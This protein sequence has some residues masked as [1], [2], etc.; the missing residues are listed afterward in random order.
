VSTN[1]EGPLHLR[2]RMRM[3]PQ[4]SK[5][6][7][8]MKTRAIVITLLF[9]C[10]AGS[11]AVGGI[12][13]Q[14]TPLWQETHGLDQ[15]ERRWILLQ[16]AETDAASSFPV[17][18][19]GPLESAAISTFTV[20]DKAAAAFKPSGRFDWEAAALFPAGQSASHFMD[21]HPFAPRE[22][23]TLD[24]RMRVGA[25]LMARLSEHWTF[26]QRTIMDSEPALDPASRTKEFHQIDASVEIPAAVLKYDNGKMAV[27]VGRHWERWGPGWTGSLILEPGAAPADGFGYSWTRSRWSLRY[28]MGRLDD[29]Q[30]EDGPVSRFLAGHR[31]DF[32]VSPTLRIGLAETTLTASRTAMPLW[33]L[34]PLLPWSMSQSEDRGP[35][36]GSNILWSLDAIWNPSRSWSVYGQ[37]LLDDYMIDAEDRDTHPDQLGFLAGLLWTSRSSGASPAIWRIALEYTRLGSWTYVHRDPELRYRSWGASL[38]H[39]AGPDSESATLACSRFGLASS[40]A[41][42]IWARWHR[43]GQVWLDTPS[44]PVGS[45]GLPWPTQPESH[46]WQVGATLRAQPVGRI[47]TT[48]RGGW[49]GLQAGY[50]P[51]SRAVNPAVSMAGHGLWA[52][53]TFALP[54][55]NISV[56]L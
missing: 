10:S 4:R 46:W 7:M 16:G 24:F 42:I 47:T 38:G 17:T 28:R 21:E 13:P 56:D 39:A 19:A 37:F 23:E 40:G 15:L 27:W 14:H 22:L 50:P 35:S 54:L 43:Q 45:A 52:S 1:R 30:L 41:A 11:A 20:E 8:S 55:V 48:L 44:G 53:L 2:F 49:T 29:F 51:D 33:M 9:S 25:G 6:W 26:W 36:E 12:L 34:N 3:L 5:H 32:S 18:A 31:L